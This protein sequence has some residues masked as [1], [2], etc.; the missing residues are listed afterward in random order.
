MD[1]YELITA[2][3]DGTGYAVFYLADGSSF[4]QTFHAL[5]VGD[6]AEL[7]V[8]LSKHLQA[9]KQ[10]VADTQKLM[11]QRVSANVLA[12]KGFGVVQLADAATLAD[13]VIAKAKLP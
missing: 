2:N 5:P 13:A 12:V 9:V 7:E 11:T 4:G 10:R 8:H 1:T 6:R 3:D